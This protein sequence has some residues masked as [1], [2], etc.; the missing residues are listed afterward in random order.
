M[1]LPCGIYKRIANDLTNDKENKMTENKPT[2]NEINIWMQYPATQLLDIRKSL[3]EAI[4][5]SSAK[6]VSIDS[7][8]VTLTNVDSAYNK[9]TS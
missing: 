1:A 5:N 3:L 2:T 9:L 6:G 7:M 4:A 8:L